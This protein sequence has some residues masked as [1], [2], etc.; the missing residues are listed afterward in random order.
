MSGA[1]VG[2]T[3]PWQECPTPGPAVA[4]RFVPVLPET[5]AKDAP[6]PPD[7][8]TVSE[9]LQSL[10]QSLPRKAVASG[11]PSGALSCNP[12][13]PT[14]IRVEVHTAERAGSASRAGRWPP[15]RGEAEGW[16]AAHPRPSPQPLEIRP[17]RAL[18]RP[19]VRT[20]CPAASLASQLVMLIRS[21]GPL[22]PSPQKHG[23]ERAQV[24]S[25]G[26]PP[27]ASFISQVALDFGAAGPAG[28]GGASGPGET[29]PSSGLPR[30]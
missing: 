1:Q 27:R 13:G 14:A 11:C 25:T 3:G 26:D 29:T 4:A 18:S 17:H 24:Q 19:L 20:A 5:L 15:C 10:P 6:H 23:A 21:H 7:A 2:D 22:V 8:T 9:S 12:D 28:P 30:E 16:G